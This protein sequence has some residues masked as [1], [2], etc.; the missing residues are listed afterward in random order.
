[1]DRL[2]QLQE[3]LGKL[4]EI[5]FTSTGVLQR[6]A[7]LMSTNPDLPITSWK[8]EQIETNWL[9]NKDLAKTAAKD[10]VETAKVIDFLIDQLPGISENEE[11][12]IRILGALEEEN[13]IAGIEMEQAIEEAEKLRGRFRHHYEELQMNTQI[14]MSRLA[15][16]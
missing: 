13:R 15:P 9:A 3:C 12:Q 4:T 1:M 8:S 16:C 7:P 11:E 2:T 10:I 5:F 14:C 6:D